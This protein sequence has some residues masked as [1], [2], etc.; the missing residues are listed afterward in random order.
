MIIIWPDPCAALEVNPNLGNPAG[1]IPMPGVASP[2]T[3]EVF[4]GGSFYRLRPP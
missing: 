1:C 2:W 3:N 4:S